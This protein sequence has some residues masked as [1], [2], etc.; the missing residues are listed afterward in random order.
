[1]KVWV[2][3]VRLSPFWMEIPGKFS[4]PVQLTEKG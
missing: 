4:I 3:L 1:L 2:Y